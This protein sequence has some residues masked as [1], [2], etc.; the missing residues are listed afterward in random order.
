V[1]ERGKMG[2]KKEVLVGAVNPLIHQGEEAVS[3]R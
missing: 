3:P 2:V 1:R